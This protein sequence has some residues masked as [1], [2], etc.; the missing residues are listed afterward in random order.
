MDW[1]V[2][3]PS[4]TSVVSWPSASILKSGESSPAQTQTTSFAQRE[5]SIWTSVTRKP[6]ANEA[7]PP[8]FSVTGW[9]YSARLSVS[10]GG[11]SSPEGPGG[12]A[13]TSTKVFPPARHWRG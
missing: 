5:S 13:T 8:T 3:V 11:V 2:A 10:G 4:R 9:P 6:S 1:R 12:S 7:V